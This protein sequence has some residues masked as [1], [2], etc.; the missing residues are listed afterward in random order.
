MS[1]GDIGSWASI[2]GLGITLITFMLA[3]NVNRK[4]NSILKTKSDKT[5]FNKKVKEAIKNLK[6][7]QELAENDMVEL[8]Y[9]TKQYCNINNAIDLVDASWDVLL[10]YET[11]FSKKIK[12]ASWER[13]F[14]KIE[15]MYDG[16]IS[17][18][19]TQ[20]VSYLNQF[21]IFLEKEQNNNG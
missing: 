12:I 21:I 16:K 9:N 10:E 14:A 17:K 7:V 4:V 15:K 1:L 11:A 2:I 5:F 13:K 3:A 8:L 20:L 6:E 19:T 18:N